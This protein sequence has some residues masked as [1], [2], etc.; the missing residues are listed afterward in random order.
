MSRYLARRLLIMIPTLLGIYT[1]TFLLVHATPGGPW[2]LAGRPLPPATVERIKE[3]YHLNDPLPK[4]YLDYLTNALK[5]DFGPSYRHQERTVSQV[6]GPGLRISVQLSLASLFVAMLIGIPLGIIAAVRQNSAADYAATL[7]SIAGATTPPY[8]TAIVFVLVFAVSLKLFPT[9]GW[10]GLFD[11][12]A[13]LPI[14]VLSI[15]AMS[16]F[17]R[18]TR[19]SMLEVLREDYL[20]TARARGVS[21]RAILIRHALR[22]ALIPVVTVAGILLADTIIGSFFVETIFAVP[23]AG[24]YYVEAVLAR[25]YP[26]IL[27]STLAYSV[28][29]L[30]SN[31]VVDASYAVLDPRIRYE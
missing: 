1:L 29:L 7:V 17:A 25:D 30:V 11:R 8:V 24:Y 2:N 23:G 13:V 16:R 15:W 26:L 21:E 9:S 20:R 3:R 27:A 10:G 12:R 28:I 6:L 4:Q 5:G 14:V 18:Y 19:A 31:L 22:N